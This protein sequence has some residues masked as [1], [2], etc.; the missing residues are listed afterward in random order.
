MVAQLYTSLAAGTIEKQPE[1]ERLVA[2]KNRLRY[3]YISE[4]LRPK[5]DVRLETGPEAGG[6]LGYQ[7]STVSPNW[8]GN[9]GPP[10]SQ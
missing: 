9:R 2:A 1:A 7:D 6:R 3:F 4:E 5:F 10:K 8:V